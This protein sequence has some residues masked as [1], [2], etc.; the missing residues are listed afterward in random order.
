MA[1][2]FSHKIAIEPMQLIGTMGGEGQNATVYP[3]LIALQT[4]GKF[5]LEKIVRYYPFEQINQALDDCE[6][7]AVIKPVL[8]MAA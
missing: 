4:Q 3:A 5:P 8:K 6:N 2:S 1:W 7:D